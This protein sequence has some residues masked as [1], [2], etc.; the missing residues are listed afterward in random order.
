M[1]SDDSIHT[2]ILRAKSKNA[3]I[4]CHNALGNQNPQTYSE[5]TS[6]WEVQQHTSRASL[7][8]TFASLETYSLHGAIDT[9]E[10]FNERQCV[11]WAHFVA[12][13][14]RVTDLMWIYLESQFHPLARRSNFIH[15][16][17]A[18]REVASNVDGNA[19][20]KQPRYNLPLSLKET[21]NLAEQSKVSFLIFCNL[22][23]VD[24]TLKRRLR[25]QW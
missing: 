22:S 19:T 8:I 3:Q 1:F 13:L 12:K 14:L 23:S 25:E 21:A 5:E 24:T 17:L 4:V 16:Q 10:T 18:L 20:N 9:N 7:S 2:K 11:D 15:R 6:P